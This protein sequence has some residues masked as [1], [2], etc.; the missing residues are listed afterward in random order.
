MLN[1]DQFGAIAVG[2]GSYRS[3]DRFGNI[4][5]EQHVFCLDCEGHGIY[6]AGHTCQSCDG[7]GIV[8][9]E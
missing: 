1:Q 2:D 8:I 3:V 5:D 4:I 9:K 6:P 7:S